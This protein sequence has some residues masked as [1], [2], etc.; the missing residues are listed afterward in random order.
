MFTRDLLPVVE[1]QINTKE[2]IVI[3]GMRRVGKTTL[4]RMVFEKIN[5]NNKLFL[6][7]ENPIDQRI[8]EEQDY[9][10]IIANLKT[11]GIKESEKIY[12]FLDEI[13]SYPEIVK[14]IKYLYDH[15]EIKFFVT[16]SSS[17]YL[18]DL[19]PESLAG[20]KIEFTLYPLTFNEFLVFKNI[21]GILYEAFDEKEKHKNEILYEKIVK[22]YDEYLS[23]GGFPQVVLTDNP[24]QKLL[25]IKDIFKSY[26][27]KEVSV[28]SNIRKILA[29]RELIFLLIARAGSKLDITKIASTMGLTRDTVYSYIAFLASTYFIHLLEPYSQS[30]DRNISGAKKIYMSDNGFFHPQLQIAEVSEGSKLENAVFLNLKK[31]GNVFYYQKRSGQEIDFIMTNPKIAFEI[32]RKG[33]E[34]DYNKLQYFAR[35][36]NINEYYII[37][38]FFDSRKGFIP[39]TDI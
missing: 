37:N 25:Q 4:L 6:D 23:Y 31:Y 20:R 15:H 28:L 2:I 34:S 36:L 9:N 13:Q 10:N 24:E 12:L 26:F 16:G 27:E 7:I 5:S 22:Y 19:F 29:F 14:A 18:K 11:Y 1:K 33:I 38:Y 21:R 17:Y 3:T 35:Q 30:S 32:K 8:F 39:V